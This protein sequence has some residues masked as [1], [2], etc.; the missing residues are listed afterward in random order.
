MSRTPKK[1][2]K[3]SE[4][5]PLEEV[6]G[7]TVVV[8]PSGSLVL[9]SAGF[10]RLLEAG[11]KHY[12]ETIRKGFLE[13]KGH[14]LVALTGNAPLT[15]LPVDARWWRSI[16]RLVFSQI[17]S[18]C[19]HQT[20]NSKA[21]D[22]INTNVIERLQQLHQAIPPLIFGAEYI[23]ETFLV[24]LARSMVDVLEQIRDTSKHDSLL[25]TLRGAYPDWKNI[26]K[27]AFHIAERPK[28]NPPFALLV[29]YELVD[30]R[31]RSSS[32]AL[33]RARTF[34]QE[35]GN[36]NAM[37][38]VLEQLKA[39]SEICPLLREICESGE[40][41]HPLALTPS[42]VFSL[43]RCTEKLTASGVTVKFPKWQNGGPRR[44]QLA[45]RV[46][47]TS[48]KGS[49]V[50]FDGIVD[51]SLSVAIGDANLSKKDIDLLLK[52]G[53]G[54]VRLKGGWVEVD[55]A[56]LSTELEVWQKLEK[57][58]ARQGL[59]LIDALKLL[60][61]ARSLG[62]L[63]NHT[64]DDITADVVSPQAGSWL[65]DVLH[66]L[67]KADKAESVIDS[68]KGLEAQLRNYQKKG[69]EWLWRLYSLRLSGVL[70][71]DMGLGKTIQIIALLL[72]I[73]ER[74][75]KGPPSLLVV[76]SSLIGNWL[77]E[78]GRFAPDLRSFV[79]HPSETDRP[80]LEKLSKGQ[81]KKYDLIITTYAYLQR[82]DTL[83]SHHWNCVILDEAQAI[84][85]AGAKQTREIKG[86]KS[87]VRFALTGTPVENRLGDLW[88]LFDFLAPGL[89]G[90]SKEF[91][92]FVKRLSSRESSNY[93]PLRDLV[94]PY[95]LRRMKTD[96]AIISDLPDKTELKVFCQL[97]KTQASLYTKL[98]SDMQEALEEAEGVKRKGIILSFLQQ[99]KQLCNHP[100]HWSG[101]SGYHL[102]S[103]GKFERLRELC[104]ELAERQD[105]VLVFTQ[106]REMTQPLSDILEVVFGRPGLVLHGGTT[107]QKRKKMVEQFAED[108]GPPF[109]VLSL[110]AGG[111]GLN[112][113]QANHVIHFDRWWNPAVEDQATDRAFRIGQKRNV[114]V[115][116]FVT[117]G[118]LEERIDDMIEGK[119]ALSKNILSDGAEISLT[120]M[121][122]D[123]LLKLVSLD[124]RHAVA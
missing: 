88:S 67:R 114:M 86:L 92:S 77:R 99:F 82:V 15:K 72:L 34:L 61:G 97:S 12:A 62:G 115:H 66:A 109:F 32:M 58:V 110:K 41:Y 21:N 27:L 46:G 28:N 111:T 1:R 8:R 90:S 3:E 65:A 45:V 7:S 57:Q 74:D 24:D 42:E 59:P 83:K 22:I 39:V 10:R 123:E 63:F 107:L 93:A 6:W 119:R 121:S 96:K 43:L 112:L 102:A 48:P 80:I 20:T 56:T 37:F 35:Q 122:N 100:S 101:D 78:I 70:A 16:G 30:D 36:N 51:F 89:L 95:I 113:T 98:I 94:R 64:G 17:C 103:S 26:G 60:S 87:R 50:G 31:G 9:T 118:T 52:A 71:D 38:A 116:K 104:A 2:T 120:E 117:R 54:L 79:A 25:S 18:G 23:T 4:T 76:P 19:E 29:T 47:E 40:I 69:V 68:V 105:R 108:D 44:P 33:G 106:F 13:S 91:S 53:D 14:G 84:K 11:G 85:N 5:S 124:L 75:P 81:L 49:F 55:A 73:K